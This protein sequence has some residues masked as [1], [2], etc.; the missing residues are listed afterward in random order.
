MTPFQL[1]GVEDGTTILLN[2]SDRIVELKVQQVLSSSCG[3]NDHRAAHPCSWRGRNF[4]SSPNLQKP[5]GSAD[6]SD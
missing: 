1:I 5:D 3:N 4:G 6:E 2:M